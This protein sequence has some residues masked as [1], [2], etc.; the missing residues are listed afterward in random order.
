MTSPIVYVV[1][2]DDACRR[3]LGSL[4]PA[5][6]M[7][8]QTFS[9]ANDFLAQLPPGSLGCLIT[10]IRMPETSGAELVKRLREVDPDL[11]VIVISG[12]FGVVDEAKAAELGAVAVLAKPF[13]I[14]RLKESLD[15]AFRLLKERRAAASRPP[16]PDSTE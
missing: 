15:R 11:P 3:A 1:D 16:K 7:A 14:G 4:L 13:D 5:L 6:G 8:A 2:D 10:D 9:N 12:S